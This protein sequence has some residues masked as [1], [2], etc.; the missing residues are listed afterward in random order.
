MPKAHSRSP[1]TSPCPTPPA[2]SQV[3]NGITIYVISAKLDPKEVG[4]MFS[5]AQN[6]GAKLSR[7]P[8]NA[9]VLIT[10]LTMKRRLERHISWDVAVRL[11]PSPKDEIIKSDTR[12]LNTSYPHSGSARV[13]NK[14]SSCLFLNS[15]Q[16][17]L[18]RV[19]AARQ[20]LKQKH[21]PHKAPHPPLKRRNLRI[22]RR[23]PT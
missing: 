8:Q 10:T 18:P 1:S 14:T 3:L 16:S 12:T 7:I 20:L 4:E 9:S 15:K 17:R 2:E 11:I 5:L 21:L 13:Q 19:N 6:S 23:R 22:P